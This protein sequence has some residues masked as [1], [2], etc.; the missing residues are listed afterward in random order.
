VGSQIAGTRSRRESSASTHAS[1]LSVL[2]ASGAKP[3]TFTASAIS[4]VQPRSSSWSCTNRAPVIDS[5]AA[6]TGCPNS[7]SR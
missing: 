2:Q 6:V 7:A 4:T 1:I 3:L 5:M